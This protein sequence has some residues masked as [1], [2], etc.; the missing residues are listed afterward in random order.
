MLSPAQLQLAL[1]SI[2]AGSRLGEH[3]LRLGWLTEWQLYEAL[4][5]QDTMPLGHV[6]P[7]DVQRNASRAL[8]ARFAREWKILPF[9]IL[10]GSLFL[11][12]AEPPDEQLLHQLGRLTRLQIRFQLVTATNFETLA[13]EALR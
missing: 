7:R 11:A 1:A 2:P 8:P 5:R 13:H 4:S 12:A 9:K 3:L 10:S 6:T